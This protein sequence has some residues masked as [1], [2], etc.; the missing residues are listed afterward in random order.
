MFERYTERARR[1]LFFARY[2]ASN[3]GS[4][5]IDT[6]HLLLGVVRESKGLTARVLGAA[7]VS[8][9]S[10]RLAVERQSTFREKVSTSVEI[11]FSG[12]TKRALQQAAVEADGLQHSYIGSEHLLLALLHDSSSTAGQILAASGLRHDEVHKELVRLINERAGMVSPPATR[13]EVASAI[14]QIKRDVSQLASLIDHGAAGGDDVIGPYELAERIHRSL[15][16]LKSLR[17]L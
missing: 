4:I 13:A 12:A 14:D 2:E 5:V 17:D 11:P 10:I 1:S 15:D 3:L 9:D 6:E 8:M 16:A 7:G